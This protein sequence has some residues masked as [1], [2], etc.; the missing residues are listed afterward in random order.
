MSK[1]P[2]TRRKTN[3][4]KL[5]QNECSRM[6]S[7]GF[8]IPS[9]RYK[10]I[11]LHDDMTRNDIRTSLASGHMFKIGAIILTAED[12]LAIMN[13]TYSKQIFRRDNNG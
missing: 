6:R 5:A 10:K 13:G 3:V 7:E 11:E 1:I 9:D 12:A 4:L 8:Q 2:V